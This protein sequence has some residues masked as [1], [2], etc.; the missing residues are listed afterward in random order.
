MNETNK[1]AHP[2]FDRKPYQEPCLHVYGDIRDVTKTN[3]NKGPVVD[4]HG[5]KTV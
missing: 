2:S 5:S 1:Q 4:G 3:S